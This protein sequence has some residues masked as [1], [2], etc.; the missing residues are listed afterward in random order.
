MPLL[1]SYGTLQLAEVQR[2]TYG[3]LLA[4]AADGLTGYRLEPIAIASADVVELSGLA[5]HTI[6]RPTGDARDR[7]AGVR[8][9]LTAEELAATDDYEG[10]AYARV[11]VTLESGERAFVY[12]VPPTS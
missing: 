8:F 10:E 3:R 2:A 12:V 1:F 11:A 6:A 7:I 4:G 5:V 9:E